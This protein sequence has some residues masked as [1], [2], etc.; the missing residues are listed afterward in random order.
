MNLRN[1]YVLNLISV[2]LI[3]S[4]KVELNTFKKELNRVLRYWIHHVLIFHLRKFPS[5]L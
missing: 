2:D 4:V 1:K 3:E 5:G